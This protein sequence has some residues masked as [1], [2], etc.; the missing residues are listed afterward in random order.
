MMD[1]P[2]NGPSIETRSTGRS[3]TVE[4]PSSTGDERP[5]ADIED[6]FALGRRWVE[7]EAGEGQGSRRFREVPLSLDDLRNPQEGDQLTHSLQHG[8]GISETKERLRC[9]FHAQGRQD[10]IVCDDL[11]MIW[12]DPAL[13]KIAPD[14]A[15]IPAV[16]DPRRYRK[17]FKVREEGTRPVFV[18][19]VS[20]ASTQK[21]DQEEKPEIYRRA[22]VEECFL[23]DQLSEPWQLVAFQLNRSRTA[24]VEIKADAQGRYLARTLGVYFRI[25]PDGQDLILEDAAS[26]EI[27]RKPIDEMQGRRDA[28]RRADQEAEARRQ[29]AEARRQEAEAR[30][31]A[32]ARNRELLAEI[33]RLRGSRS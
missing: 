22:E 18:L 13:D 8:D 9:F 14:V 32:E 3:L 4:L 2:Y 33:E 16:K 27:L 19:E 10:V 11:Q 15:V 23:L 30:E 1:P 21:F 31:A 6:P 26:G 24:Y 29:E 7:V 28:E 5:G 25:S 12:D 17:S 20:S